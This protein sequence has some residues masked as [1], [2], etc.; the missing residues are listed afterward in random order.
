MCLAQ[1]L[2]QF[3]NDKN[4]YLIAERL[5]FAFQLN[6]VWFGCLH[7]CCVCHSVTVFERV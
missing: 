3:I 4:E 7:V 5:A 6:S 1:I 2:A